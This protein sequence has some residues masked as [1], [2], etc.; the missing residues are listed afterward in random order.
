MRPPRRST[1]EPDPGWVLSGPVTSPRDRTGPHTERPGEVDEHGAAWR[2]GPSRRERLAAQRARQR[3][4]AARRRRRFAVVALAA[5][6]LLGVVVGGGAYLLGSAFFDDDYDGPGTGDV[7]VRV[8]DGDST[9]QIGAMLERRGVVASAGAFTS[10]AGDDDR[11][12]AVQPGYYQMSSRMSAEAAVARLLDPAA[13]VGKLEIRGGTQLDDTRTPDGRTSPGVLSLVA[14][15][16]CARVDGERRCLSVDDLRRTM[17]ETDPADLGVPAWAVDDVRRA[18]P[19][20]R[21]EGLIAPGV[22]DVA[23]GTSAGDVLRELLADS[24]PR[25]EAGGLADAQAK[26]G[27][28]PYQALVV[29]SLVEKEGIT[30]DMPEVARV[31]YNRLAGQQR[32]ELDSTVNYPLDVQALR[33]TAEARATPGP[34]NSYAAAGLP[35]TPIAAPGKAAVSAALAPEP[36]PWLFFVRCKTDGTSCFATTLAEHQEN[37]RQAIA[38]GAF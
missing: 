27:L 2:A 32:L 9:S 13:R 18:D 14:Q 36:G 30:P 8:I 1:T 20:R 15:A 31:I 17:A 16:S 11:V 3:A 10:A 23:P 38:A 7:V 21:L 5:L 37:V 35:P 29:S 25:L 4:E 12:L 24:I 6:V 19:N 34:Y 28:A 26:V 33:T 22:Y